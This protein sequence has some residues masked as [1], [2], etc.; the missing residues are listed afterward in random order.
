MNELK[1]N[2]LAVIVAVVM[3]FVLGFLWYG[4][5]FGDAWMEMVGLDMDTADRPG[6]GA[7]LAYGDQPGWTG[8]DHCSGTEEMPDRYGARSRQ[9]C[10]R[11]AT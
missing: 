4:P 1:I 9:L 6:A 11:A 8:E 3:Q 7:G 5:L 2:H 10:H